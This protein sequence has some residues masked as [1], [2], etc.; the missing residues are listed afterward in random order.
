[1][2]IKNT[3][4]GMLLSE[5]QLNDL[6]QR[7]DIEKFNSGVFGYFEDFEEYLEYMLN[8]YDFNVDFVEISETEILEIKRSVIPEEWESNRFYLYQLENE[9]SLQIWEHEVELYDLQE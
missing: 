8:E 9:D 7:S 2:I 3:N 6:L 1:M 4:T 5:S